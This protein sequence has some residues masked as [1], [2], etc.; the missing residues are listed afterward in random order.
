MAINDL[1]T[2]QEDLHSLADA[3]LPTGII[4]P[5]AGSTAPKGWLLCNGAEILVA[6][7]QAL[8]A[9]IGAT[10][11]AAAPGNVRLPDLRGN[12]PVG[13]AAPY[14]YRNDQGVDVPINIGLYFGRPSESLRKDDIPNH[15]HHV[16][17]E[18]S[19]T[20]RDWWDAHDRTLGKTQGHQHTHNFDA[21]TSG[22]TEEL[23]AGRPHNNLQPALA[24]NFIIKT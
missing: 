16:T 18:T 9:V 24:V 1:L 13:A 21:P 15:R 10:Y 20:V 22:I 19:Q 7:Y 2:A 11:G 4:V 14:Q 23:A 8:A 12:V 6:S 17:G 5:Y 3:L